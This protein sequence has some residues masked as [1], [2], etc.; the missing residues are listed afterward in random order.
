MLRIITEQRGNT[1]RLELHGTV[2]DEGIA[3][4][5]RYWRSLEEQV[6]SA[7]VN[8]DLANVVFIDMHGQTLLRRMAQCG[9]EFNASGCLNRYVIE[10]IAGGL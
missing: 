5:E 3:V 8:I 9:V 1:F 7:I 6:P 2:A 10:R 4:L